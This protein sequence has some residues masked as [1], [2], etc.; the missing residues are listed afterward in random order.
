MEADEQKVN[1]E[2]IAVYPNRV[3]ISVDDLTTF[4]LAEESLRVG[5]YLKIS[6]NENVSLICIIESFAIEVK[7]KPD[8]NFKRVYII[9]AYPLG[10]FRAGSLKEVVM[11]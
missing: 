9:E 5:S 4:K 6:D 7:E 11:N 10:R 1:A 2:V 8:G 3:K